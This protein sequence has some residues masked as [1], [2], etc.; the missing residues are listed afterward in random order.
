MTD[1]APAQADQ[2]EGAPHPRETRVLLGQDAAEQ[3]FLTAFNDNRLHHGWLITGPRGVGKA[4]LAWRIATFLL[5]TPLDDGG[6]FVPPTPETLDIADDHPIRARLAALSDPGLFLLR[7]PWDEEKKRHKAQI[8]VDEVRRLKGFFSL[9]NPDGGRRVVIVDT[10][11]DMN[12]SAANALLK[13]LEE[14]PSDCILLLISHQPSRLL[15]TIRSRCRELRCATLSADDIQRAL[16]ASGIEPGDA[17]AALAELAAGSVGEAIGLLT[18]SGVALYEQL[19]SLV[20]GLPDF[21]RAKAITLG[22][23]LAKRGAEVE[24]D[25][26]IRLTDTLLSRLS[27]AGLGLVETEA[28]PGE[29]AMLARLSPNANASR[30]WASVAAEI[31][32]RLRHGQGVNL[33]PASLVLDMVMTLQETAARTAA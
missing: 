25:L 21:D 23:R 14:P 27:R 22:D 16:I 20:A 30:A 2:I 6:M 18:L 1:D 9:T 10:A 8:A 19:V 31:G 4:T 7:R 33:D 32:A 28:V 24:F 5:A 17:G 12:P 26:F 11:D 13:I 15:P 29:A 3:T